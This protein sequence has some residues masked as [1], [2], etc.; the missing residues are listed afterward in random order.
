MD[1]CTQKEVTHWQDLFSC[2]N[3]HVL[4][5]KPC[6]DFLGQL[7]FRGR[8][9]HSP[10]EQ[11]RVEI[12]YPVPLSTNGDLIAQMAG[13]V[14]RGTYRDQQWWTSKQ[15]GLANRCTMKLETNQLYQMLRFGLNPATP[16]TWLHW[17]PTPATW[18]PRPATWLHWMP[19]PGTWLH[20]HPHH[21]MCRVVNLRTAGR[22]SRGS[23]SSVLEGSPTSSRSFSN[24]SC[25]KSSSSA[26]RSS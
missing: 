4:Y 7:N 18:M 15:P 21:V 26:R 17:T 5:S 14:S 24:S 13:F 10:S 12:P 6:L 23:V 19:R 16:A 20:R 1:C 8:R 9:K 3:I 11:H 25:S 2:H 22:S